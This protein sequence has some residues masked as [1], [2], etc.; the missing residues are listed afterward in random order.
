MNRER[1]IETGLPSVEANRF[2]GSHPEKV[3]RVIRDYNVY[4]DRMVE[5][6]GKDR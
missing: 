2:S 6:T 5:V 1:M 3:N 4:I